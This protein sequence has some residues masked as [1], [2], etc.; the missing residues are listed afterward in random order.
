MKQLLPI[1]A[2][3]ALCACNAPSKEK[4][5]NMDIKPPVAEKIPKQLV[6][7]G[8]TRVDNYYWLNERENPKV[9]AYLDAENKYLDTMMAHTKTLQDKLFNE[10]KGRIKETD[11]SVPVLDNGYFYYTRYEEGKEYP[12]FCRKQGSLEAKEEVMLD[13]NV[14]AAGHGYY[15]VSGVRVSPDNNLLL[16][17]VDDV[18]RRNYTMHVKNL[19]TGE[20]YTD[21][22][23]KLTGNWV[24]ANDNKTIYYAK[25]DTVTLRSES[26]YVHTL[27][28]DAAK[29][30]LVYHEKDETFTV[31]LD[32]TKSKKYIVINSEST[33]STEA[34]ILDANKPGGQ[35]TVFQPREKDHLYYI[36]HRENEFYIITDWEA[37]NSRIM[38]ANETQFG[39]QYWKEFVAHRADVLLEGI[40]LFKDYIV[41]K[42][43][44]GGLAQ[45]RIMHPTNKQE[46]YLDF[47]E[48]A[49][50]ASV[51]ANPE[52][53]TKVLRY[54]YASLVTPNSTFD[55]NMDTREKELKKQQE[56]LGGYD[57]KNYTI[58][59]VSAK[60]KDGTEVPISIVYKKGFKKD[61]NGPLLMYGYGSYGSSTEA[62]FNSN[63]ISL[64]D[65]G[66]A[67]AIAHIRGG[68]EMGR[69]WYD[70]GKMFKK[71]NTFTDFI[72]CA[73]YLVK[74]K[75]TSSQHLYALGGSAGGLLMGA[76]INMRP[77]LWHGVIA[78]V[79]FVDVVTTMLDESIPLTTG[80]FDEWGNPKNKD[81]YDYM[82]SYSPYDNVEKKAYPNMLVTTG[83]HDSQ[84]QYFE[85]AK[86]VA[87]LRDMKTDNNV[88]LFKTNMEAGHGGASG[89]FTALKEVALQYAF[90]LDL[91]GI[92]K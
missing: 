87:K 8:D 70:D 92:S 84:V 34:R 47:G 2:L 14:M 44:K 80:E 46:H 82:K 36:D 9:L 48:A 88:L 24:W 60:A 75:Y 91:E 89:R 38:T 74:E 59:R 45:M 55:Y 28:N 57:P 39:K 16:Y 79:P 35:F 49:Y 43:R 61:G 56:V 29:D 68:Q 86:W 66:F 65:R 72:D 64:L 22:I 40:E 63:R 31:W 17:G 32:Q 73:D 4:K 33:V 90:M 3:A 30:K 58:E 7:H 81:S 54:N 50:V 37:K 1:I 83:L 6:E 41:I 13:V 19:S 67:Y 12:I 27:G 78:A 25:K 26:I 20:T 10:M 69:Q 23:P 15:S 77:E 42:E 21:Q 11:E 71:K 51:G 76:I 5:M 62:G 85:P 53:D 18:G 52:Y